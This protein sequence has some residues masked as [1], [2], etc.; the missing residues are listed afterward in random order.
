MRGWRPAEGWYLRL[1][2]RKWQFTEA[3]FSYFVPGGVFGFY[4][5]ATCGRV[6]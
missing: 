1:T 3:N 6:A 5:S 2:K 4:I